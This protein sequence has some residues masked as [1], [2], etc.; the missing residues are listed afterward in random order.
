MTWKQ[1]AVVLL[2]LFALMALA[3]GIAVLIPTNMM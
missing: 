2:V 1:I 3:V